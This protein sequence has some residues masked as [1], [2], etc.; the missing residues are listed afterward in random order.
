MTP[1]VGDLAALA[2]LGVVQIGIAYAIF[3]YGIARVTAL[4]AALIGML[5]P[6]LNP[7]WVY[8]ALGEEP[9]TLAIAGGAV[10][11]A[12]VTVRTLLVERRPRTVAPV[13]AGP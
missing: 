13:A 4:E 8:L 7:V 2:F 11:I 3:G 6:V 10:I 1:S 9:G 12:A 5:E